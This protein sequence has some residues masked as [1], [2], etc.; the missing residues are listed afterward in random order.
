MQDEKKKVIDRRR[1]PDIL[2]RWIQWS[3]FIGWMLLIATVFVVAEAKPPMETIIDR[4]LKVHLRKT[5]DQ[6]LLRYCFYLMIL[7]CALCV[8][9]FVVNLRRN[10]RKTD[11]IRVSFV[12][13]GLTSIAGMIIYMIKA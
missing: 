6:D 13:L 2:I 3:A 10:K 7:L 4:L 8:A 11:R 1:G 5:W 9:A 12:L